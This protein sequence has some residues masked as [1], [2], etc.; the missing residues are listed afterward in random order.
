MLEK[1]KGHCSNKFEELVNL[2]GEKIK[3]IFE[4]QDSNGTNYYLIFESGFGFCW[5]SNG[6]FWIATPREVK[7]K[8]DG[9]RTE[10]ELARQE[11]EL[12][13]EMAGEE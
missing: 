7:E 4:L 1:D 3:G 5:R 2:K 10:L 8:M 9:K 11:L 6:S 13:L 12:L